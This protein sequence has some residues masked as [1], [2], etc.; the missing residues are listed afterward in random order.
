M[1]TRNTIYLLALDEMRLAYPKSIRGSDVVHGL[2]SCETGDQDVVLACQHHDSLLPRF[3]SSLLLA[4]A[5]LEICRERGGILVNSELEAR[6]DI[7]V[8]RY[9]ATPDTLQSHY[10]HI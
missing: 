7:W 10:S 1:A 8:V 4:Q 2:T 3:F 5:G 9:L 6:R